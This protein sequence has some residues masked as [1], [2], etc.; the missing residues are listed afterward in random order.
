MLKF[1]L[2]IFIFSVAV[3]AT[4]ED[5]PHCQE[6]AQAQADSECQ[7]RGWDSAENVELITCRPDTVMYMRTCVK[8]KKVTFTLPAQ[9]S[10]NT[11]TNA[12]NGFIS[13]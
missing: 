13:L 6:R 4:A 9:P 8:T 7:Q 5:L 11:G 1:M 12:G 3:Y 2:T 10:T